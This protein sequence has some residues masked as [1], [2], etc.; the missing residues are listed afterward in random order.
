MKVIAFFTLL[1]YEIQL[2]ILKNRT[3]FTFGPYPGQNY[4][5]YKFS[6]LK[7]VSLKLIYTYKLILEY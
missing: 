1:S 7:I 4:L 5:M 3:K 6:I 2:R